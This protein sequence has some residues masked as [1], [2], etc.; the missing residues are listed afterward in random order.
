MSLTLVCFSGR[1]IEQFNKELEENRESYKN[2][3]ISSRSITD[4][5]CCLVFIAAIVGFVGAS[6]Y[7]WTNGNPRQLFIGW[8]SDRNGCGFTEG[9][10]DYQYL[11]WPEPPGT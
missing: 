8:D 10:E 2:G 11:Y 7:G 6:F 1:Q 3:P 4:C 5:I 9:F